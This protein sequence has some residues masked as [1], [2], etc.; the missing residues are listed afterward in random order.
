MSPTPARDTPAGRAYNDL[1]NLAKRQGR[2]V[3]EYFALYTLKASSLG[4]ADPGSPANSS[5]KAGC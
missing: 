4:S 5:S 3:T 1:K 2:D